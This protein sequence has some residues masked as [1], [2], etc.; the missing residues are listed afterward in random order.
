V[1]ALQV[2]DTPWLL[3]IPAPPLR[4]LSMDPDCAPHH[5]T[6]RAL[7]V[8]YGHYACS[9]SLEPARALLA[10]VASILQHYDPDLLLTT[11]GDS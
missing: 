6:P 4:L 2:E 7:R 8:S 11:W 1:E 3:D 9:L 10:N 5:D